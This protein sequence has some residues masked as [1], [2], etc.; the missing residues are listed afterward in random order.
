MTDYRLISCSLEQ[1]G[2]QILD[3]FNDAI[4]N[5]TALYEYQPRTMQTIETWFDAKAAGGFPVI[6]LVDS[7]CALLGFASY[8]AFRPQPAY[9]YT[10]EHSVYVHAAHRGRGLGRVLLNA[11]VAEAKADQRHALIGVIDA[12]NQASRS[13]HESLGFHLVGSMPQVAF[14]F[15]R[16]LDAVMYQLTLQTPS[17]PWD[18]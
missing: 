17:D 16:W 7:E 10:V 12:E 13:L 8:G 5:S 3:I 4:V 1:H 18:G 6:G 15:G 9:K 14:K 11:I 2:E